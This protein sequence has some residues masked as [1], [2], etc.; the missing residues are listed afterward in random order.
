MKTNT[1]YWPY[2]AEFFLEWE[3]FQTKSVEKIKTHFVS[4][5]CIANNRAV[6]EIM[7]KNIVD[8]D[9]PDDSTVRYMRFA[10]RIT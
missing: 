9:R 4:N 3:M 6:Y 5:T 2:L 10:C 7:W 1:R 8:P